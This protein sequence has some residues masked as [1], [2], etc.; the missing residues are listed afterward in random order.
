MALISNG[1]TIASGG[2]LSVSASP[3]SSLNAVGSTAALSYY[4]STANPGTTVAPNYNWGWSTFA[5]NTYS[6]HSDR[7][8]G[9]WRCMGYVASG[10]YGS[11]GSV[12][13]RIS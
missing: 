3:P 11:R 10:N 13:I 1:T 8:T 5:A 6:V 7:P 2:S 12:W 9:T 4:D